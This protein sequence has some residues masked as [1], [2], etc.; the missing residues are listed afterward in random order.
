MTKYYDI[1]VTIS[2]IATS[3][4]NHQ[5]SKVNKKTI[6]LSTPYTLN[7]YNITQKNKQHKTPKTFYFVN[8]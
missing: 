5:T 4:N 6:Y 3:E 1:I 2:D 8:L 7:S